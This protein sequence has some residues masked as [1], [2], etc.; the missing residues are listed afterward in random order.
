VARLSKLLLLIP[1][2]YGNT[3]ESSLFSRS[4]LSNWGGFIGGLYGGKNAAAMSQIAYLALGLTVL[5]IFSEGGGIGY[6]TEPLWAI[7]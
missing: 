4:H 1:L 6:L 2:G 5:P 7:Y 3:R